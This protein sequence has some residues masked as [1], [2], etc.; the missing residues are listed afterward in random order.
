MALSAVK[1]DQPKQKDAEPAQAAKPVK[2]SKLKWVIVGVSALLIPA[3]G[4][5]AYWYLNRDTSA[6]AAKA[7]AAKPPVFVPL[8]VFTVNLQLEE[9]PQFLQVGLSLRVAD[10]TVGDSI[11]LHM[12]EIR[13]SILLL[14]SSRKASQLL[15]LTGKNELSTD[16]VTAVN[17][18]LTSAQPKTAAKA[19]PAAPAAETAAEPAPEASAETPAA[20]G[21][22]KQA[23]GDAPGKAAAKK[24]AKTKTDPAVPVKSVL[25]TSFIVQ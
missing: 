23:E 10:G 22:E 4:G 12:P 7:E 9:S 5:G 25:F 24:A 1:K 16:I 14:L 8:D 11:K 20:E 17:S 3:I 6:A 2:K 19:A 18:I 21:E 15:T 13:N